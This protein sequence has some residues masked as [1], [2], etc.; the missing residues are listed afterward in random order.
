MS[1]HL[2]ALSSAPESRLR[3]TAGRLKAVGVR[4]ERYKRPGRA[5]GR[6]TRAVVSSRGGSGEVEREPEGGLPA[7]ALLALDAA[8][9]CLVSKRAARG[10]MIYGG[11]RLTDRLAN[12]CT[13]R[14]LF[15]EPH[16]GQ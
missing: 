7:P 10:E 3:G 2:R 5:E 8:R 14:T 12:S 11:L 15:A 16:C 9:G 4:A 1:I 13:L 6:H